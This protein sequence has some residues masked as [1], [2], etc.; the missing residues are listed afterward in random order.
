MFYISFGLLDWFS[1]CRYENYLYKVLQ[2]NAPDT[3]KI[4]MSGGRMERRKLKMCY[5]HVSISYN[6][7]DDY[8]LQ[9]ILVKAK[10]KQ[11]HKQKTAKREIIWGHIIKKTCPI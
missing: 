11:T 1:I 6:K 4:E 5:V 2:I 3:R 7:Y 10:N 8:V 9:N